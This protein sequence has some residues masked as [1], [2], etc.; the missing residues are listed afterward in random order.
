M[1][2]HSIEAGM[3]ALIHITEAALRISPAAIAAKTIVHHFD[4][5]NGNIIWI[6]CPTPP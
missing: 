1:L 4:A 2:A 6:A 3:N 5:R